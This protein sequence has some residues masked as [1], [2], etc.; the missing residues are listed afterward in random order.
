MKAA[1]F[2][3][4]LSV[5]LVTYGSV[6]LYI[7]NRAM[8]SLSSLSSHKGLFILVLLFLFLSLIVGKI[9]ERV[10]PSAFTDVLTWIGSFWMAIVLFV[11]LSL[12][13]IDLFRLINW[14]VPYFPSFMVS[15]IVKTKFVMA[16]IVIISSFSLV[17]GGY[18]NLM[19]PK[20]KNFELTVDKKAGNLSELNI[21]A[22]TD[23]HLSTVFNKKRVAKLVDRIN[24]LEPDIVLFGG[25]VIEDNLATVK[26]HKLLEYFNGVKSKYGVYSITGNHEYIGGAFKDWDYYEDNNIK[27]VR[28]EAIKIDECF[29][30]VGRED[31]QMGN[32]VNKRRKELV[33]LV[34]GLDTELPII[35]LDHQPYKLEEAKNNGV[36]LQIS[37]HT[38]NGQIWPFNY[39]TGAI[40]EEDWGYLKKDNTHYY[41]SCG[42]GTS[43][44]PIRT[45]NRPEII[46]IKLKFK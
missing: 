36:D 38:H 43:G 7:Y 21:V 11:F 20:I 28:D 31:Y 22:V 10:S 34:E 27:L 32:F 46:N 30:I 23:I 14:I 37:G 13:I 45:G 19:T 18:I 12:V 35:L 8:Q 5:I 44:P 33:E 17:L 40:F 29:Y 24:E 39:I 2:I 42:Y 4:F 3:I 15:N 9:V 16:N 41:I 26:K 6:H 25:D 1:T